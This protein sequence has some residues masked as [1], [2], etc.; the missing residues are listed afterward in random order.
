MRTMNDLTDT[1]EAGECCR[2]PYT[3]L[4]SGDAAVAR[5]AHGRVAAGKRRRAQRRQGLPRCLSAA[6][7]IASAAMWL[8]VHMTYARR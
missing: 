3:R 1:V 8:V 2:F 4:G 6:D 7:R 5:R